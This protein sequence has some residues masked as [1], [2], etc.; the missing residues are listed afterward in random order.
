[1][2]SFF[3]QY[4][5]PYYID[6]EHNRYSL[7]ID[8]GLDFLQKVRQFSPTEYDNAS[9]GTPYYWM[10]I[11]AFLSH[12]FQTAAFFFD[13]AVSED[14]KHHPNDPDQPSLLT[15]QLKHDNPNQAAS[16]IVQAVVKKINDTISNYNIVPE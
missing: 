15:M 12:D 8:H 16:V 5:R 6:M 3:D 13:A 14:L 4:I 10:G 2:F 1:M 7:V 11:A 9:K